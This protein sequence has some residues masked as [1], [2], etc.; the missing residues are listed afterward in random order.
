MEL[1]KPTLPVKLDLG[2]GQ[3]PREG[4]EAVDLHAP[5]VA[6]RVNLFKFP[7]PFADDSVDEL[8]SSHFIEHLP[9]REVEW[10]DLTP[11][12]TN[13][14]VKHFLGQDFL[15][16]FFDECYRILKKEGSM[17]VIWPALKSERAF[18]DPTHRRFIPAATMGYLSLDWRKS[19]KL[20]HY[21]VRCDFQ[22]NVNFTMPQELSLLSPEHQSRRFNEMWN[23]IFDYHA[24]LKPIK[25]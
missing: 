24:V 9:A 23:T 6:H 14:E 7:W 18:Q 13:D 4:F 5:N 21:P 19:Q 1:A 16:A 11:A 2:A 17:M 8:H 25:P 20:D 12:A 10:G 22:S 3:N 15:L